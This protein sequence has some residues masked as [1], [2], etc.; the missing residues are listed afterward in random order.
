MTRFARLRDLLT[1][2]RAAGAIEAARLR[3][4]AGWLCGRMTDDEYWAAVRECLDAK[5]FSE[6][7]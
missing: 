4:E 6:E 7:G 1:R 3:L 5:A 2:A